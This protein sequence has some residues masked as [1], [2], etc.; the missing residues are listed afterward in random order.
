MISA[1]FL[2]RRFPRA[3][4]AQIDPL[5]ATPIRLSDD[6][7][8]WLVDFVRKG[9]WTDARTPL[10]FASSF[11]KCFPAAALRCNSNSRRLDH[12]RSGMAGGFI[13]L[14]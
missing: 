11:P 7:F 13:G 4:L 8:Q 14:F 12:G 6:E 2:R 10:T 5:L 9:C 3:L 1:T